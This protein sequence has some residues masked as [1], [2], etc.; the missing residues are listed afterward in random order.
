MYMLAGAAIAVHHF[1]ELSGLLS[2]GIVVGMFTLVP[3]TLLVAKKAYIADV[4]LFTIG[5]SMLFSVVIIGMV[6]W[7]LT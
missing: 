3:I 5:I 6:L 4:R 1:T 7:L 2:F